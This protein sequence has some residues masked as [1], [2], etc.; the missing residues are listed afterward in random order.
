M[1]G[2]FDSPG[3]AVTL[4]DGCIDADWEYEQ[5]RRKRAAKARADRGE[6]E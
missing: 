3:P 1:T 5:A 4:N 2:L 6:P